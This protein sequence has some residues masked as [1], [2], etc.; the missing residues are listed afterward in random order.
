MWPLAFTIHGCAASHIP[1]LT[2][3]ARGHMPTVLTSSIANSKSNQTWSN[4]EL[5]GSGW[6]SKATKV[7]R[8]F[9]GW[10]LNGSWQEVAVNHI[11]QVCTS[12][13]QNM[14]CSRFDLYEFGVY[15][16]RYMRMLSRGLDRVPYHR[17]WGL[18]SFQGLPMEDTRTI[19]SSISKKIWK[20]GH[21]N[22]A[23]IFGIYSAKALMAR[24]GRYVNNSRVEFISGFYNE[25]LTPTLRRERGMRPAL[26]AEIDCDLYISS[27]QALDWMFAN[28]L[29]VRH[30][31]IGYDDWHSG[32]IGGQR[33]A[34]AEMVAK[35]RLTL[36]PLSPKVF[37]VE[38]VG[39]AVS[40]RES[41]GR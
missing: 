16:G 40:S 8:K 39:G 27:V 30:S 34:H 37:V 26:Y 20:Q 11:L 19:K 29:L 33:K 6:R 1:I 36:R 10:N 32:G 24:I 35:Y 15:I 25:S 4:D 3:G 28:G 12:D 14:D 21:F 18:D 41:P 38:A 2:V 23:D 31:V 5:R 22:A 7:D 13:K 17:F 9:E